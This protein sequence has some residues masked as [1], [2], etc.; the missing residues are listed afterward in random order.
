[1]P[2]VLAIGEIA[3]GKETVRNDYLYSTNI[4]R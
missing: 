4:S 3:T 1:M 2:L